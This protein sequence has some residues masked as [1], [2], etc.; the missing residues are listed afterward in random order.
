L[1]VI[2]FDTYPPFSGDDPVCPKCLKIGASVEYMAYGECYHD[3][4]GVSGTI[5]G[6]QPNERL[7]RVC[8][9]CSYAWDEN[10]A[11]ATT[12]RAHP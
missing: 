4:G 3:S 8:I 7:H 2:E 5:F 10:L 9:R 12:P 6:F 1:P 11:T